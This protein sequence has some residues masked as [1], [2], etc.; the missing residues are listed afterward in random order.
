MQPADIYAWIA[1][2]TRP[3]CD[4]F[5][6]HVVACILALSAW[7]AETG[8]GRIQDLV[9]LDG[10]VIA[11]LAAEMF[12]HTAAVFA[13]LRGQTCSPRA[14]DEACLQDLLRRSVTD[15]TVLQLRLADMIAR[16]CLRPNHLWQDL[17]LRNRRE[18]GWMLNRHFEP[19]AARNKSDMKWKKFFYRTI[20]RDDGY[21]LCSAP[22]CAECDDFETCFGDESGESLLAR[23]RCASDL[24]A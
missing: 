11:D 24:A 8:A 9:G 21:M 23:T 6:A 18:L 2:P 17:G 13:R 1:G 20:C 4:G 10:D 22:S 16:R 3:G 19:L 5:D 15:G 14:G 7:E 12:P